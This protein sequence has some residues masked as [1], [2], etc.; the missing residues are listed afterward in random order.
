MQLSPGRKP[1]YAPA[2]P[3][4]SRPRKPVAIPPTS[5]VQ[6]AAIV[7]PAIDRPA[8]KRTI[9][10]EFL[11]TEVEYDG[12]EKP[13]T[14]VID[15][16]TMH[17]YLVLAGGKARRYGVGVGRPASNGRASTRS[18]ARPSGRTGVRRRRCASASRTCR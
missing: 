6:Q 9:A 2:A 1:I 15:T 17:L 4:T 7:Q 13:G 3:A 18:P 14:I 5:V 16:N 10:P 8:P 12:G 11:P